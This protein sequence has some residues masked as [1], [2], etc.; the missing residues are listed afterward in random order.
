MGLFIVEFIFII[1]ALA[2]FGI[3]APNTWRTALWKDGGLNEFNSD[4]N[5][6]L[7]AYANHRPIPKTPMV[8]NQLYV[9]VAGRTLSG[10]EIPAVFCD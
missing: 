1:P 10:S 5:Q 2:I 7:Y 8:W 3:A 4:P 9:K 6:I